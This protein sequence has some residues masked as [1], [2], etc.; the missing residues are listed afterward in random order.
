[1]YNAYDVTTSPKPVFFP[2]D[3][4]YNDTTAPNQAPYTVN[5]RM[6]YNPASW[7]LPV[8]P[9]T[10][11]PGTARFIRFDNC[12]VQF[13]ATPNLENWDNAL[14]SKPTGVLYLVG[15]F[16]YE[17]DGTTIL[18]G[19]AADGVTPIG[20]QATLENFIHMQA[21]FVTPPAHGPFNPILEPTD[22]Y[23]FSNVTYTFTPNMEVLFNKQLV[24]LGCEPS[25]AF[26]RGFINNVVA[27]DVGLKTAQLTSLVNGTN[28]NTFPDTAAA[29]LCMQNAIAT[30]R[31][32]MT[33]AGVAAFQATTSICL[34]TLQSDTASAINSLIG[35]G[36][37]PCNS[38]FT[39]TPPIQFT[40]LPV[41]VSVTLNETNGLSLGT[42]LPPSVSDNIASR[43]QGYVTFGSISNFSYDGYQFFNADI[44]SPISGTGE[45]MVS[46]DNNILCTNT[47]PTDGSNPTHTLQSQNY[48]FIYTPSS[49]LPGE[50]DT[51][52]GVPRR[53]TGDVSRDGS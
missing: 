50:E 22:G 9:F 32:N 11:R 24:T 31:S 25:I 7:H 13:V 21:D 14:V 6:F 42:A 29:E 15:G 18:H 23:V 16:G 17:D 28:G 20:N 1:M 3:A 49:T 39:L 46:F 30:L 45:V 27:S 8:A 47:F 37:D 5:L 19:F 10:P 4:N 53:D 12:I 51:S 52:L 38:T 26:N 48:E 41:V 43:L 35:I 34:N 36:V 44:T 40:T 33:V 2:T